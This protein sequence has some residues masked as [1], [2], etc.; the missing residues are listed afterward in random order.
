MGN[1]LKVISSSSILGLLDSIVDVLIGSV[2]GVYL[3]SLCNIFFILIDMF[4]TLYQKFAGVEPIPLNGTEVSQDPVLYLINTNV[5]QEIFFS[6]VSLSII[7][8]IIFTIFA[9]VKNIYTDKPK[10]L[11]EIINS[12]VKALLMYL[13]VPVATV[14]CLLVGNVVLRAIDGATKLGGA[15]RMSDTLFISAAYNANKLRT[16]ADWDKE[17]ALQAMLIAGTLNPGEANSD[18]SQYQSYVA[19]MKKHN[20]DVKKWG[21]Q[22]VEVQDWEE[23]AYAVDQA[24][25]SGVIGQGKVVHLFVMQYYNILQINMITI[26][27]GGAFMIWALGKITWGLLGRIFKMTFFYAVSPAV[28][29]VFPIKGDNVLKSWTGEMVKNGTMAYC[30]IGTLNVV[31]SIL[32]A[33]SKIKVF[34]NN[35]LLNGLT[36]LF[37]NIV[38]LSSAEKMISTVSSWFGTGDALAEGKA[39]SDSFKKAVKKPGEIGKK[40]ADKSKKALGYFGGIRGGIESATKQGENKFLGALT[41]ALSQTGFAKMHQETQKSI[42]DGKKQGSDY[43]KNLATKDWAGEVD[44]DKLAEYEANE[45]RLKKQKQYQSLTGSTSPTYYSSIADTGSDPNMIKAREWLNNSSN[46]GKAVFETALNQQKINENENQKSQ[47]RIGVINNI[48]QSQKARIEAEASLEAE[49]DAILGAGRWASSTSAQREALMNSV[50]RNP[51]A[52][53]VENADVLIGLKAEYASAEKAFDKAV[54][55]HTNKMASDTGY[56]T[57]VTSTVG[58]SLLTKARSTVASDLDDVQNAL[59]TAVADGI[60]LKRNATQ[61]EKDMAEVAQRDIMGLL[62]PAEKAALDNYN[63]A[64]PKS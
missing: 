59:N 61:L 25:L 22:D 46:A 39:T 36:T 4:E 35:F 11:S 40:V 17:A 18:T 15:N 63:K 14:V 2:L 45:E 27:A 62:T 51:N 64:H 34:G 31:L 3:W 53:G 58:A 6:I 55:D 48:A 42:Q 7:L 12:S 54:E 28:L 20:I 56:S 44:K 5:V 41:G 30:A 8:L 47:E 52:Y 16:G 49:F 10:P 19:T 43:H 1:L 23:V 60:A 57:F 26:W 24:F 21:I 33:F 9:I 38:A 32:P 37:I 29:A 13:L 50:I